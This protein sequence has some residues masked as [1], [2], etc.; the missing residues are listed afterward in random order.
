MR[1]DRREAPMGTKD[2][3]EKLMADPEAAA[4]V[5]AHLKADYEAVA[6]ADLPQEGEVTPTDNRWDIITP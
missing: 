1:L 2:K 5:D 6:Q 3:I 4:R